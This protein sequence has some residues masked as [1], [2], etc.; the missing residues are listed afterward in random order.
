MANFSI[1]FKRNFVLF[2][3]TH[4]GSFDP[5]SIFNMDQL[6]KPQSKRQIAESIQCESGSTGLFSHPLDC[7]KFIQCDLGRTYIT[8]CSVGTVFNE[9][10]KVCDWPWKTSC[11]T[12][13]FFGNTVIPSPPPPSSSLPPSS[14]YPPNPQTTIEEEPFRGEGIINIRHGRFAPKTHPQQIRW[15]NNVQNQQNYPYQQQ[16]H[17][18]Y[19]QHY[20]PQHP[21][22]RNYQH[23][24]QNRGPVRNQSIPSS[25]RPEQNS[26]RIIFMDPDQQSEPSQTNH[27]TSNDILNRASAGN[28]PQVKIIN[29]PNHFPE[30]NVM[31][32]RV[33]DEFLKYF[34]NPKLKTN[35]KPSANV[36]EHPIIL[37][38][39]PQQFLHTNLVSAQ[40]GDQFNLFFANPKPK[41]VVNLRFSPKIE[42]KT[43]QK[44]AAIDYI[45]LVRQGTPHEHSASHQFPQ[46][47]LMSPMV[48][49][50]FYHYF[51]QP[52]PETTPKKTSTEKPSPEMDE[53]QA[54][55]GLFHGEP[56]LNRKISSPLDN[57]NRLYFKPAKIPFEHTGRNA[58]PDNVL[59]SDNLKQLLRSYFN[60]NASKTSNKLEPTNQKADVETFTTT[61]DHKQIQQFYPEQRP[62]TYR[63]RPQSRFPETESSNQPTYRR[64]GAPYD[65]NKIYFPGPHSYSHSTQ[66]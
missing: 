57:Y 24:N 30:V 58:E 54:S 15:V 16:H 32:K 43:K 8:E 23:Q 60:E 51:S 4:H 62:T 25:K 20:R 22:V 14:P 33:G 29:V 63:P 40:V 36:F 44:P 9:L 39:T 48:G 11:G 56:Q 1:I 50:E 41:T 27:Y 12:R 38:V 31:T 10:A 34:S 6:E 35:P 66:Y 45:T 21:P 46:I 18:S 59:I 42:V 37:K 49:N 64:P 53:P 13:P 19:H 55:F 3:Q 47:N 26:Y 65:P 5:E 61:S 28:K 2:Q 17:Q 52:K 7:S